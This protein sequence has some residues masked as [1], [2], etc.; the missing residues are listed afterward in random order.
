ML[1]SGLTCI[2]NWQR[3]VLFPVTPPMSK[4][5]KSRTGDGNCNV[6][7]ELKWSSAVWRDWALLN[8]AGHNNSLHSL[9]SIRLDA[10]YYSSTASTY[11]K[12]FF[13]I[14]EDAL[15]GGVASP[16]HGHIAHRVV[17]WGFV[18]EQ[19]VIVQLRLRV[20]MRIV[21]VITIMDSVQGAGPAV[22][23]CEQG[24]QCTP[25]PHGQQLDPSEHLGKALAQY[26]IS[27]PRW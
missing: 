11:P 5:N 1:S 17:R 4:Q 8:G 18:H 21:R 24:N 15:E 12:I 23:D 3:F 20:A 16:G 2:I 13:Q 25:P 14:R 22:V 26:F 9:Y 6:L 7:I 19:I 10:S 27:P